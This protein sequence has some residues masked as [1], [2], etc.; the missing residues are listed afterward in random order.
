MP[1][2]KNRKRERFAIEV[3]SM[4]PYD[5]AYVA[6]GFKDSQWAPYNANKLAHAPEVEARIEELRAEFADRAGL[7]AE[8]LQRQLLPLVEANAQDLFMMT[9]DATGRKR[10]TLRP[11][12][13]LPRRL[14]AAIQKI[15]FDPDT[16]SPLEIALYNKNDAGGTLLRS[17]GGLT[18]RLQV[19]DDVSAMSDADLSALM[20]DA[21]RRLPLSLAAMAEIEAALG[22]VDA[23]AQDDAP[24]SALVPR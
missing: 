7:H 12:T 23:G 11:V 20:V 21:M 5:R 4:T 19:S 18:D 1:K 6:A 15:K 2:L 22:L 17:V 13:E 9:A 10:E 24:G 3:A 16:G 14:A 8:Y